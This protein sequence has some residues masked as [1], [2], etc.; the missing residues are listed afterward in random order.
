MRVIMMISMPVPMVVVRVVVR[1]SMGMRSHLLT[2]K[3]KYTPIVQP[4]GVGALLD[5]EVCLKF[6]ACCSFQGCSRK[7]L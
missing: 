7:N 1:V 4:M 6:M 5:P 3:V 2:S